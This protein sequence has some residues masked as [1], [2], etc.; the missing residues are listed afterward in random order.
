MAIW[1]PD[2]LTLD[3]TLKVLSGFRCLNFSCLWTVAQIGP[4]LF[5]FKSQ[6]KLWPMPVIFIALVIKETCFSTNTYLFTFY[7]QR[8]GFLS[9]IITLESVT[10]TL[11]RLVLSLSP[12]SQHAFVLGCL[13]SFMASFHFHCPYFL[14]KKKLIVFGKT[15]ALIIAHL[16]Q[17]VAQQYS[18]YK[19]F[20]LSYTLHHSGSV[21]D[22]K[23]GIEG[24]KI[25]F[26][27]YLLFLFWDT[28][29][30]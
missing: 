28:I 16:R 22:M 30:M 11:S 20:K 3:F 25:W 5:S 9:W 24:W 29:T 27:F 2:I 4:L 10:A 1:L 18:W 21:A 23:F 26:P 17:G 19:I 12:E 15:I 14:F 8:V 6:E 7:L 13:V